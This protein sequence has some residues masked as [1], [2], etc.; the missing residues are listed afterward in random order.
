M[1]KEG[2]TDG[3]FTDIEVVSNHYNDLYSIVFTKGEDLVEQYMT[4]LTFD[5]AFLVLAALD[6]Y[7][8]VKRE[9]Q[10]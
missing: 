8:G 2:F 6:E 4:G 7:F 3:T 9:I 10:N 5:A 1:K